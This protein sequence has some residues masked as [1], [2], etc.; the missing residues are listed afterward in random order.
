MIH[1]QRFSPDT[2]GCVLLETWDDEPP[3]EAR[4]HHFQAFEYICDAH[5]GHAGS[6]LYDRIR[7]ENRRK[8]LL[9]L[10]AQA[11]RADFHDE[12]YT[13]AFDDHRRLQVTVAHLTPAQGQALQAMADLQFGPGLVLVQ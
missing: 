11:L 12:D 5:T 8:N 6:T 9:S 1:T 10:M 4:V 2:C 3:A 13:W 7:A